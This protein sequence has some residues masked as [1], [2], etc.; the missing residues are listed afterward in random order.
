[1]DDYGEIIGPSL[2]FNTKS[3]M[4]CDFLW[5]NLKFLVWSDIG[6]FL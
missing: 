2:S 4:I 5:L 3:A 1:M 6:L